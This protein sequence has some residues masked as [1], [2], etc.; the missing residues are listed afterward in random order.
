MCDARAFPLIATTPLQIPFARCDLSPRRPGYV[1]LR[2]LRL[3]DRRDDD[4]V[5]VAGEHHDDPTT[6]PRFWP[7]PVVGISGTPVTT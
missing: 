1:R 2:A 7:A 4:H 5:V 3:R 6:I